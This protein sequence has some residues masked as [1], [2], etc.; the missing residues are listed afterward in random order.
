MRSPL[1]VH[2]I[3]LPFLIRLLHPFFSS[4]F[5]SDTFSSVSSLSSFFPFHL[6]H[7]FQ[8]K[9]QIEKKFREC[10]NPISKALNID[11]LMY[12]AHGRV[13]IWSGEL[14][15]THLCMGWNARHLA[16]RMT[17]KRLCAAFFFLS[18]FLTWFISWY[19]VFLEA[20][21]SRNAYNM[22][23]LQSIFLRKSDDRNMKENDKD[24]WQ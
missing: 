19:E 21:T 22:R 16:Y 4:F 6:Y 7:Q 12:H 18:F 23:G 9:H 11:P 5:P 14:R 24:V 10:L 8:S 20:N 13:D 15:Q 17:H 1:P 2:T 3:N